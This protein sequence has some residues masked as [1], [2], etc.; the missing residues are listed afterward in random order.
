MDPFEYYKVLIV[1]DEPYL[2]ELIKE[3][4]ESSD[5]QVKVFESAD[6]RAAFQRMSLMQFDLVIS[7]MM[8]PI[9]NGKKL[10]EKSKNLH[11]DFR[12]LNFIMISGHFEK[13]IF[14]DNKGGIGLIKKPFKE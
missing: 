13:S 7:D 6:G 14:K 8:M 4:L 3:Y 1:D 5:L 12:P 2:R 9:W 10:L 11:K